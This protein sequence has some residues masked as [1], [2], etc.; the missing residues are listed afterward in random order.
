MAFGLV[1]WAR[2]PAATVLFGAFV[3]DSG[4]I[5][6]LAGSTGGRPGW[7]GE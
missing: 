7:V 6:A 4:M 1:T 3:L 5:G 2:A